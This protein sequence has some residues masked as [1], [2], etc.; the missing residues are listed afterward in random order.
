MAHAAV[1]T[2]GNFAHRNIIAS[3]AHL[4]PQ[5]VMTDFATKANAV[6]PVR[7]YNRSHAFFFCTFVDHDVTI[8][9]NYGG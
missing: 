5:F 2:L 4:E 6:E 9:G 3:G 8:L 7:E 1:F